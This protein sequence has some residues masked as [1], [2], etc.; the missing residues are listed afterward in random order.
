MTPPEEVSTATF[1]LIGVI[2]YG[3]VKPGTVMAALLKVVASEAT[4]KV[5]YTSFEV[6]VQAVTERDP[7]D[8]TIYV[9][10]T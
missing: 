5:T 1:P 10:Q 3:L 4:D 6:I 9:I 7:V 2:E 8:Y